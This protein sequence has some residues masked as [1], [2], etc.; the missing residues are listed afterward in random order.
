MTTP[1]QPDN[2]IDELAFEVALGYYTPE[3]LS[4]QYDLS[5]AKLQFVQENPLFQRAVQKYRREIDESGQEFKFKARK[6]ASILL[7]EVAAIAAD[8]T[9]SH[10]DRIKAFAE[11]AR[12]A[13]YGK[14]DPTPQGNQAFQ[15]NISFSG[16]AAP[17]SV[18]Y[19]DH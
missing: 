1:A 10:S 16:A 5:P 6:L 12:M 9:A 11:L 4:V 3:E 19:E 7:P 17:A 8:E 14:E 18:Q 2:W 15:V 13:G